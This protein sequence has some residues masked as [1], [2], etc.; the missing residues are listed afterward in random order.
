MAP[1]MVWF[2]EGGGEGH[3]GAESALLLSFFAVTGAGCLEDAI[4]VTVATV[5]L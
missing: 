2:G 4:F 3:E 1:L 5:G